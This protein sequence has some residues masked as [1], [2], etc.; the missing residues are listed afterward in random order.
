MTT[1]KVDDEAQALAELARRSASRSTT[2]RERTVRDPTIEARTLG[3][4]E[5]YSSRS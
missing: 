4:V 1:I 2:R 3:V 5:V